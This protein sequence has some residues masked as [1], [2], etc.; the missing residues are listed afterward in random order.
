MLNQWLETPRLWPSHRSK[1]FELQSENPSAD[2]ILQYNL[3]FFL[4]DVSLYKQIG[5]LGQAF[6]RSLNS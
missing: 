1:S 5:P 2:G 3:A 4:A 6:L